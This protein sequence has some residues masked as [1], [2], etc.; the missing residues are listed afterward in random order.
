MGRRSKPATP[1]MR[2]RLVTLAVASCFA[3]SVSAGGVGMNAVYG[4]VSSTTVGNTQTIFTSP[5]AIVQF[6]SFSVWANEI[7][8]SQQQSASSQALYR[9]MG[10]DSSSILGTWWSNGRIFLINPN[11]VF[12]GSGAVIDMAGFVASSL[13]LSDADFLA[14]KF[15]FNEQIGAGKVVNQG[16]IQTSAGGHVYLIA[17]SVE[18]QGVI[19][20]PRGEIILAAGKTVE[21]VDTSN[22]FLR[23]ELTAPSN[24]AINVGK[25]VADAGS[26]GIYATAIRQSG[27][28]SA[29]SATVGENGRII[30][31]AT[32]DVVLDAGSRTEANGPRGGQIIVQAEGGTL[33]ASGALEA[34][35]RSD[36]GGT[37]QLL[38][39]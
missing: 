3:G 18:N 28:V 9:V 10:S 4:T 26:V 7:V 22:P 13:S 38:G 34:K 33:L 25:I 2:A 5:N 37:V 35:G 32:Q 1:L 23:V 31:K 36:K 20:S 39:E 11:G 16:T 8:R 27:T 15:K 29:N 21:L 30:F 19:T 12:I 14:G 6:Q 17:P 24:Q